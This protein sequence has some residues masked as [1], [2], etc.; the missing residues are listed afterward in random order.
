MNKEAIL[1]NVFTLLGVSDNV[2]LPLL[3]DKA[4]K[5][6]KVFCND[7]FKDENGEDIFPEEL[8]SALEDLVVY[9]Y[10]RRGAEGFKSEGQGDKNTS[11]SDDIPVDIKNRLYRYRKMR[12]I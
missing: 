5:D 1:S 12:V 3:V 6:I 8:E 2:L 7:K 11:Y 10:N 9:R 4:E